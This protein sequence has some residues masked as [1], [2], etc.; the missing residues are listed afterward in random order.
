MATQSL[1]FSYTQGQ[2][3]TA[4]L[5]AIGSDAV[6]ATASSVTQSTNRKNRYT[7]EF[8]DVPA[9]RYMLVYSI[10]STDVGSEIYTLTFDTQISFPEVEVGG[11]G[12]STL[13]GPNALTVTVQDADTS[14]PI[15]AAIVRLYRTGE[16]GSQTTDDDGVT[17][18]GLT[19][20]TW[21]YAVS[22]A[23]YSSKTGTIA[24]SGDGAL[25]VQ[26]DGIVVEQADAPYCSTV[27]RVLSQYEGSAAGVEVTIEFIKWMSTAD[28]TG[29][30][31]NKLPPIASDSNGIVNANLFQ[32]A[33]YR[34]RY[35][36]GFEEPKVVEFCTPAET[37]FVV[38]DP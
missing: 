2:T 13:T 3:L 14:E 21:S 16:T 34:A 12:S 24:V 15:E 19:T 18:F 4:R 25:L 9:G 37:S 38:T 27:L 17:I 29:V 22:A 8:E 35:R 5:F 32:L 11:G 23:G 33:R 31:V 7:A 6:V 1:E 36:V 30:V 20:A 26:L 28:P 10:G